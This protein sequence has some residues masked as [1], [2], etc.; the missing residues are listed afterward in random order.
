MTSLNTANVHAYKHI[1]VT[2]DFRFFE[3]SSSTNARATVARAD[4]VVCH[5][6][7]IF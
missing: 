2:I 1:D 6:A 5:A 3:T 4:N 7:K